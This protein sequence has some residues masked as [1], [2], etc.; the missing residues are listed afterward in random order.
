MAPRMDTLIGEP[1]SLFQ[2]HLGFCCDG[3]ALRCDVCRNSNTVAKQ[4]GQRRLRS[5]ECVQNGIRKELGE[6][7]GEVPQFVVCY[8]RAPRLL[9]ELAPS[10][11][12]RILGCAA[13]A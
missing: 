11:F 4:V 12:V 1:P 3:I 8:L 6:R 10:Q 9:R 13:R 2:Q 7:H 5:I